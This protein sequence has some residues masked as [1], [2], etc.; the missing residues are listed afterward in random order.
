MLSTNDCSKNTHV[1]LN[2]IGTFS[3]QK[4]TKDPNYN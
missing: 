4:K 3:H 2:Q 1:H